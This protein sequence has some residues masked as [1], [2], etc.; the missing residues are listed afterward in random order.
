M[1]TPLIPWT[2]KVP[3]S[4]PPQ[5]GGLGVFNPGISLGYIPQIVDNIPENELQHFGHAVHRA[6]LDD[7]FMV[8]SDHIRAASSS[9]YLDADFSAAVVWS[10]TASEVFVD[11]I[12]LMMAWEEGTPDAEVEKW[13]KI[14]LMNCIKLQYPNFSKVIGIPVISELVF[15]TGE[16]LSILCVTKLFTKD[17]IHRNMRRNLHWIPLRLSLNTSSNALINNWEKYPRTNLAVLGIEGMDKRGKYR[18]KIK[19]FSERESE[20]LPRWIIEISGIGRNDF[21]HNLRTVPLQR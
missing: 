17:T 18:G 20:N 16:N 1:P 21:V 19:E 10:H 8:A 14:G 13:D 3:F 5:F 15:L 12:L 7:P 9:F 2:T 6:K 4:S 11:N